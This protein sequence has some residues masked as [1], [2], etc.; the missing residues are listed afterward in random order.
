[1]FHHSIRG[2]LEVFTSEAAALQAQAGVTAGQLA[3]LVERHRF[4]RSVCM[5]HTL[6]EEE[7]RQLG[8]LQH[9]QS[10]HVYTNVLLQC[11]GCDGVL[12]AEYALC[13]FP[14]IGVRLGA[15]RLGNRLSGSRLRVAGMA[16]GWAGGAAQVPA[17]RV[18]VPHA[19]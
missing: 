10:L 3:G 13:S 16:A 9:A 11:D 4:L 14:K 1:L 7:V 2:A 5:F 19:V 15:G 6:S 12:D 18:H 8:C 17:Q